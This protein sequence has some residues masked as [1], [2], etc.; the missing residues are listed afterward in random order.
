ME[1]LKEVR[2][3][4]RSEKLSRIELQEYRKYAGKIQWLS[5]GTRPDLSFTAL[6]MAKK[7]N[8]ATIADL[9]GIDRVVEKVKKE[10][11]KIVYGEIGKKED[12]Q[13]VGIVD[14]SYKTE[15]KSV[16]G[17]MIML[18]DRELMRA[19]PI[20]WKSKQIDRVCHS[21]K[22]AETLAMLK[23]VDEITYMGM[24]IET[25]L[26][27]NYEKRMPVKVYTDNEPLLES[28]ASSKQIDRK[29][30]RRVIEGLKEK[31][32]EGD[33]RAYQWIPTKEMWSDGLTKEMEM[34][35]GVRSL[36]KTGRCEIRKEEVNKV[37]CEKSEIRMKNI[38][39]RNTK[40]KEEEK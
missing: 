15:G 4:N 13:L 32:V 39:N 23:M 38:R 1:P 7:N 10:E 34:A 8:S 24:Q 28:I 3:A 30:L 19:S 21:S 29:N 14:A 12:L 31:L 20:M 5:Q 37:I 17:M 18:T 6:Q 27:G 35:E 22:D 11:N 9:R 40:K 16:G 36:M 33:I 26:Y 2:K 25:V